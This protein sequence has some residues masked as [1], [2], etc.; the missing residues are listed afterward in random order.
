MRFQKMV[1]PLLR[2]IA[3]LA[4]KNTVIWL[5]LQERCAQ[6]HAKLLEDAPKL[7]EVEILPVKNEAAF[8]S[9]LECILLKLTLKK[10]RKTCH[11]E[12]S[13]DSE[14]HKKEIRK[15]K[16]KK[17]KEKNVKKKNDSQSAVHV[18]SPAENKKKKRKVT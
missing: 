15:K 2:T 5:C 4:N 3:D 12:S 6:A 14:K 18:V 8:A 10:P 17:H 9:E 11:P 13:K 16:K 7:F 1:L